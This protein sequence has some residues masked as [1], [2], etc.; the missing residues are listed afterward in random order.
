[1]RFIDE[2]VLQQAQ[3]A[4]ISV[5]IFLSQTEAFAVDTGSSEESIRLVEEDWVIDRKG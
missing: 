1:V 4:D 5:Q 2:V 3:L